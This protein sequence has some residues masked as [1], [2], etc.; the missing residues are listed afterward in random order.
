MAAG[1]ATNNPR[2]LEEAGKRVVARFEEQ[3]A[4]APDEA[5]AKPAPP[6]TRFANLPKR[7]PAPAEAPPAPPEAGPSPK[8]APRLAG[9]V[10]PLTKTSQRI[11]ITLEGCLRRALA[12]NLGI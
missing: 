7:A 9:F 1:C 3:K 5:P 4:A 12:N 6:A 2:G 11:P 10:D 8:P